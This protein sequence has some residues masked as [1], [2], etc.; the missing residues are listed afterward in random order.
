MGAN[1]DE[2]CKRL[3]ACKKNKTADIVDT[4]DVIK[5]FKPFSFSCL[6]IFKKLAKQNN[7]VS[8]AREEELDKTQILRIL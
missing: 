6:E 7:M 4:K 3:D 2:I 5:T 8:N 1:F